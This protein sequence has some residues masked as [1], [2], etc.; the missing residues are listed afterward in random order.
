[1]QNAACLWIPLK[2]YTWMWNTK[3][4]DSKG[5][6]LTCSLQSAHFSSPWIFI[7]CRETDIKT[8]M[9]GSER[10]IIL[11]EYLFDNTIELQLTSSEGNTNAWRSHSMAL[12]GKIPLLRLRHNANMGFWIILFNKRVKVISCIRQ[13][14]ILYGLWFIMVKG[15]TQWAWRNHI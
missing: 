4:Y 3:I 15:T 9:I 6:T 12:F 8:L 2:G 1:M 13:T 10:A 11:S 7:T 5:C 14:Q